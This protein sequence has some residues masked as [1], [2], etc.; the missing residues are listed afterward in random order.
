MPGRRFH[1]LCIASLLSVMLVGARIAPAATPE[2]NDPW[3]GLVQDIF[4]NR[5]MNDGADVIAIEM[6]YRAEDAA[7]VPVTLRTKLPPGDS[8]R[9][10]RITL[11][12]D[13]NPAPMAAKF[14]LGP[15]ANVTEIST[16]VRVNN[17]TDVHAVA[18]LS[19]GKLYMT[20]T[21]VKA[22]GG[23]SA[24]AT[25]V[26]DEAKSRLGQMR[27]RQFARAGQGSGQG[28]TSGTREAQIMIGHPSHSGL[29]MD[30]VTQL[31][32]PAF[33]VDQLRLWQDDSLVLAMEGGI[34]I[35]EDP[36]IR[37]TYVSNGATRFRAE[38]RDTKGHVFQ[39][40]WKVDD[41]GI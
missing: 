15:D 29:Q 21:Y 19:D 20:K 31:Y 6:P 5:P 40:E 8:R 36:N 38:A 12:I 24:P 1:L 35:S 25:K 22:S 18:E 27:Y 37:F 23:C 41:S 3:P 39:K 32:I 28:P 30:Q 14:E 26:A 17:Y 13:Q 33:F 34:S 2:A 16:R 10:L 11:V 9:V 4:N 7:I